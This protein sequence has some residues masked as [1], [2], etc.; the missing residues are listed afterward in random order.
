M[1]ARVDNL[2]DRWG[3]LVAIILTVM[4]LVLAFASYAGAQPVVNPTAVIFTPSADHAAMGTY[5]FG[6][7]VTAADP[8]P[9]RMKT[10]APADLAPVGTDFRFPFPRIGFGSFTHKLR[11]CTAAPVICS[12]WAVADKTSDVRPFPASA[13]RVQ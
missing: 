7:F 10:L 4:T 6:Y 13:V 11:G 2:I 12:E 1:H 3:L 8:T 9:I 5:E